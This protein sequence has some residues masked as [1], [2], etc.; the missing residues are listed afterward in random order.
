MTHNQID[1]WNLQEQ[2]RSNVAQEIETQ[3]SN[4]AREHETN[5]HNVETEKFNISQLAEQ[6]R[7]NRVN[8]ALKAQA[9]NE[10]ARHN[11]TSEMQ[12]ANKLQEQQR[13]SAVSE[14]Q[15]A[16]DLNIKNDQLQESKRH[17]LATESIE[18]AKAA[19]QAQY[20]QTMADVA[21][22]QSSN[23]AALNMTKQRELEQSI[24]KMQSDI[25]I[26]QQS[27]DIR[28]WDSAQNAAK[29][30]SNVLIDLLRLTNRDK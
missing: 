2:K 18:R 21:R 10:Q 20:Q 16:I 30:V 9:Q 22:F 13:H 5:R 7:S 15:N 1:Y 29:N 11:V 25:Q 28:A 17:N 19:F 4:L 26:A 24:K 3:R 23:Q 8:E 12:E 27:N 14:Y 6:S